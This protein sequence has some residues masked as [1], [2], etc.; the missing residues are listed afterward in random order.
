[1]SLERRLSEL[2]AR[3]GLRPPESPRVRRA[4]ERALAAR[5][6]L[7]DCLPL[8]TN[9]HTWFL[10]DRAQLEG[11]V[12]RA[13]PGARVWSAG[14]ATGEEPY[15]IAMLAALAGARLEVHATDVVPQVVERARAGRYAELA[16]RAVEPALRARF[17]VTDGDAHAVAPGLRARVSFGVHNLCEPPPNPGGW[18]AIVCRNVLIHFEPEAARSVVARLCSALAPGGRLVLG[19]ADALLAPPPSRA[20]RPRPAPRPSSSPPPRPAT[21]PRR[22]SRPPVESGL[23]HL[24]EGND[25]ARARDHDGALTAYAN[26]WEDRD[27]RLAAEA[28]LLAGVALRRRGDL[29]VALRAL[30]E[31][32]FLDPSLWQAWW[33][34]GAVAEALGASERAAAALEAARNALA[35]PRPRRLV[36]DVVG[37]AGLDLAPERARVLLARR[38][39]PDPGGASWTPT[40]PT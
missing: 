18:D 19:A 35:G 2:A 27:P 26:A 16:L 11:L 37:L 12:S 28:R 20:P 4:L 34:L 25:R 24:N 29:D 5:G 10:R 1:M 13:R 30:R 17:F 22:T 9:H 8:V 6:G 38:A 33:T 32:T 14:C 39:F 36:S 7:E 15:S 21:R 23:A 3:Y 31:A 40:T